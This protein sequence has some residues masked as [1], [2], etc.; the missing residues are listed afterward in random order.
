MNP[1][2]NGS[3]RQTRQV[4]RDVSV[5]VVVACYTEKRWDLIL[6]AVE[7]ARS[8]TYPAA[9]IAVVVDNNRHLLERLQTTLPSDVTILANRFQAGAGGA[10]NTAALAMTSDYVAFL[11][12]DAVAD[13]IWI[14][15]LVDA[16]TSNAD[17]VG[18]GGAIRP[19]WAT[20]QPVWFPNEFEWV[21]GCRTDGP[22]ESIQRVR[23]VWA[24]NMIVD[25]QAFADAG[26]FREDYGKVG[27]ISEPEDTELCL[28]LSNRTNK[29]WALA[30][31]AEVGH[32]VTSE[33]ET[34]QYFL[35]RC[36]LEGRG[37]ASLSTLDDASADALSD[38]QTYVR[39][40]LPRAFVRYLRAA[41]AG[42]PKAFIRALFVL[43][44]VGF[45]GVGF[46]A[47]RASRLL[48]N[49]SK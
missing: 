31:G 6:R 17:L 15:S 32:Q 35:T 8:Q 28:R 14:E 9:E 45:A 5:G 34:V 36:F 4:G 7:S 22:N 43:A 1:N 10:R 39:S 40:T 20:R 46:A 42:E 2:E 19:V 38:E 13:S 12:D 29:G 41:F 11:D 24:V 44:G 33:R 27:T 47:G 49:R 21:L 37:K 26:G 3:G 48:G 18:A 30:A 25:R 23:N 16:L